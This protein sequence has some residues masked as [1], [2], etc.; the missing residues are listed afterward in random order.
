MEFPYKAKFRNGRNFFNKSRQT[1]SEK[2][3]GVELHPLSIY[4]NPF[5]A[6]KP[7]KMK[8]SNNVILGPI[9]IRIQWEFNVVIKE[10]AISNWS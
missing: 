4:E 3:E 5:L 2:L 7:Q 9:S 10:P 8:C 1:L 6:T